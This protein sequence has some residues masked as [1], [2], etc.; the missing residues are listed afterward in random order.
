MTKQEI[1]QAFLETNYNV[2]LSDVKSITLKVNKTSEELELQF[3]ELLSWCFITAWNPLPEIL[4]IEENQKRNKQLENDIQNLGLEYLN[5]IGV[6]VDG[7]WSEQS[8]FI[9]NIALAKVN[10]LA[11][12]Y[13]QLAFVF[14][15]K[16]EKAELVY[17]IF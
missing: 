13:K 10:E 12:K 7:K 16:N 2:A 11:V 14:G 8:F 15:H 9:K 4:E 3:P 1:H 17:T 6:S 5:G